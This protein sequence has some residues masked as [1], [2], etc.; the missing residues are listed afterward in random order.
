MRLFHPRFH[1]IVFLT[2]AFILCFLVTAQA[3]EKGLME[4]NGTI[5]VGQMAPP[6]EAVT[7]DGQ[8]FSLES[9]KGRPVFIDFG[10]VLCE[11]CADMVLE[12]NRM[13]KKYS[14]T[15]LDIMMIVDG[16]MPTDMTEAFFSRLKAT[17]TVIRDSDWSLLSRYGVTVVPFKVLIDR[18]GK[19]RS[20]HLGFDKNIEVLMDFETLLK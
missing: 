3:G 17:F 1:G 13:K 12:M 14:D 5:K 8:K 10:S 2:A 4:T 20:M 19:I 18:E 11:A 7:L 9:F 6:I 15:D 16:S